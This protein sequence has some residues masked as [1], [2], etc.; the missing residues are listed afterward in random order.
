MIVPYLD[1]FYFG[2]VYEPVV[3]AEDR[4]KDNAAVCEARFAD[5]S[6]RPVLRSKEATSVSFQEITE[7]AQLIVDVLRSMPWATSSDFVASEGDPAA[8]EWAGSLD[9]SGIGAGFSYSLVKVQRSLP[10]QAAPAAE[11][12]LAGT[13]KDSRRPTILRACW[14]ALRCAA[15]LLISCWC[16][17]P[18]LKELLR[19]DGVSEAEIMELYRRK[20]GRCDQ[21][22]ARARR[23][24]CFGSEL[25]L[26][27]RATAGHWLN[28]FGTYTMKHTARWRPCVSPTI[29]CISRHVYWDYQVNSSG[30]SN[31]RRN[32]LQTIEKRRAW[33]G[34][35]DRFVHVRQSA[36]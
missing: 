19:A 23:P 4:E 16:H 11:D 12:K 26:R 35:G 25:T 32:R 1:F 30:G 6:S 14:C 3:Q 20:N 17:M 28:G 18:E 15:T 33:R 8:L 13:D 24:I 5:S 2:I 21:W 36:A 34:G 27:A 29:M 10:G 7:A 22:L 9:P 31:S